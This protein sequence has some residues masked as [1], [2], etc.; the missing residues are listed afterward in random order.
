MSRV[1][2]TGIERATNISTSRKIETANIDLI[3]GDYGFLNFEVEAN[4]KLF[5][6]LSEFSPAKDPAL[7][8]SVSLPLFNVQFI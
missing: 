7:G 4:K 1:I 3:K 8:E 2:S 6:H 5:F